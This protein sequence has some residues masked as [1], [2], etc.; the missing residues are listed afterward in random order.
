MTEVLTA[1][2]QVQESVTPKDDTYTLRF[3]EAAATGD[4]IRN[5]DV[6]FTKIDKIP[7]GFEPDPNFGLQLAPGTTKGSRHIL[8]SP[9]GVKIYTNK[10]ADVLTGPVVSLTKERVA[11]HPEH[12]SV[13]LPPGD[14]AITFQRQ[15]AQELR[16]VAD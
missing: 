10:R 11:T 1:F 16:R 4:V 3:S 2:T 5:G 6:Y 15:F 13:E 14:Y 9:D 7:E 8:D 12:R